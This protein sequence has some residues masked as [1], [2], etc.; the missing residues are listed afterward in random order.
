MAKKRLITEIGKYVLCKQQIPT[1]FVKAAAVALEAADQFHPDVILCVGQA[2]GE[3]GSD[4][5]ADRREY[6][7]RPDP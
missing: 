6:P 7:G 2:G 4:T 3:G 5:G 1:V